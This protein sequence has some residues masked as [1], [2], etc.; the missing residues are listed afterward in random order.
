MG[1]VRNLVVVEEAGAVLP[2]GEERSEDGGS[3]V[4]YCTDR[5]VRGVRSYVVRG[6]EVWG[7]AVRTGEVVGRAQLRGEAQGEDADGQEEFWKGEQP[8]AVRCV[9]HLVGEEAVVVVLG[10]G[11][12]HLV[13]VDP[14]DEAREVTCDSASATTTESAAYWPSECVAVLP[15]GISAA[16][17]SPSGN[18]LAIVGRDPGRVMVLSVSDGWANVLDEELQVYET[19]RQ[20]CVE[21]AALAWSD[22]DK[23]LGVSFG[24]EAFE[25]EAVTR[26]D[27]DVILYD[28]QKST[29]ASRATADEDWTA[30]VPG[31]V[32]WFS[33]G[34][35]LTVPIRDTRDPSW[36]LKL[37]MVEKNGLEHGTAD[38][39]VPPLATST[40]A[41]P[42]NPHGAAAQVRSLSWNLDGTLLAMWVSLADGTGSVVQVYHRA[43][44]HWLVKHEVRA[45][46]IEGCLWDRDEA[47]VLHVWTA[48]EV[49]QR[50]F[51]W[52]V[53][54]GAR[55]PCVG[56][57]TDGAALALT[58]LARAPVP[59]PMSHVR[60]VLPAVPNAV[61][62][63]HPL[64]VAELPDWRPGF[65][66][67]ADGGSSMLMPEDV[68]A[69]AL[70]AAVSADGSLLVRDGRAG[71]EASWSPLGHADPHCGPLLSPH[72]AVALSP[73]GLAGVRQLAWVGARTLVLL[74]SSHGFGGGAA[75][76]GTLRG[77]DFLVAVRL[78]GDQA[79]GPGDLDVGMRM[80]L[81][82]DEE[83]RRLEPS[84]LAVVS[85]E[86]V[87]KRSPWLR[88][89]AACADGSV[90]SV[91]VDP[92]TLD[93]RARC[94]PNPADPVAFGRGEDAKVN[95]YFTEA[96]DHFGIALLPPAEAVGKGGHGPS[97]G[98]ASDADAVGRQ[99][100]D[101]DMM[102]NM[103]SD[104][105][106]D[107]YND[108]F[109]RGDDAAGGS[110][111]GPD[112]DDPRMHRLVPV[113]LTSTLHLH[114][115][116]VK[117]ATE[118]TS[119]AAHDT[120]LLV[121]TSNR[122]LR[123]LALLPASGLDSNTP[124]GPQDGAQ[125]L[126]AGEGF[127]IARPKATSAGTATLGALGSHAA[128]AEGVKKGFLEFGGP[129]L[130]PAMAEKNPTATLLPPAS[131]NPW[132]NPRVKG[133]FANA[134]R[135]LEFGAILVCAVRGGAGV[136]LQ[137]PRG[138]LE[139]LYPRALTLGLS[140]RALQRGDFGRAFALCKRHRLDLNLLCD[141]DP[142]AFLQA[143]R[144]GRVV[145]S[146]FA[147]EEAHHGIPPPEQEEA[148]RT[149]GSV[150][151]LGVNLFLSHLKQDNVTESVHDVEYWRR[152]SG[153]KESEEMHWGGERKVQA[154]MGALRESLLVAQE[155]SI[156]NGGDARPYTLCVLTSYVR[157]LPSRIEDAL[158]VLQPHF[159]PK[160]LAEGLPPTFLRHDTNKKTDGDTFLQHLIWVT[161]GK[162]ETLWRSALGMY[163]FYLTLAVL[164]AMEDKDPKEYMPW[165]GKLHSIED[166]DVQKF[167]INEHLGRHPE[168]LVHL[169]AHARKE[170]DNEVFAKCLMFAKKHVLFRDLLGHFPAGE[171]S[172]KCAGW[173]A[174][175]CV[176]YAQ[177]LSLKGLYEDSA[178]M[179]LRGG[180]F[181][182]AFQQYLHVG[183][184]AQA[185]AVA[186][187]HLV[188]GD[189]QER[190]A[191]L[192]GFARKVAGPLE[193][194]SR[195]LDAGR[196]LL[197]YGGEEDVVEGLGHL[198]ASGAWAEVARQC[199][200]RAVATEV[201][202]KHVWMP[203][204]ERAMAAAGELKEQAERFTKYLTRL[205]VVR[206]GL[207]KELEERR[208]LIEEEAERMR[209]NEG[210]GSDVELDPFFLTDTFGENPDR[211]WDVESI[212]SSL[213]QYT[214]KTHA[215]RA[216]TI[217]RGSSVGGS[218]V[219][220]GRQ[221]GVK[222]KQK[223]GKKIRAGHPKEEGHLV[224]LLENMMLG[225]DVVQGYGELLEMICAPTI[226]LPG[227]EGETLEAMERGLRAAAQLQVTLDALLKLQDASAAEIRK[228]PMVSLQLSQL[229]DDAME[230]SGPSDKAK[231]KDKTAPHPPAVPR[232]GS[233]KWAFLRPPE[234]IKLQ[235][236]AERQQVP[237]PPS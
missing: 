218:T 74:C 97:N 125:I 69:R 146:F 185:M 52:D 25:G 145:K 193:T 94:V 205:R 118:V 112:S 45:E 217:A 59:P 216:T 202:Q 151:Q 169:A 197:E 194:V 55:P 48:S 67:E 83:V 3:N 234:S 232:G 209:K 65:F 189:A 201:V 206:K 28:V 161:P 95:P 237:A 114:M 56:C 85:G 49:R 110:A 8:L 93:L 192:A 11:E 100:Q 224:G 152:G 175:C 123:P 119:F 137:Q 2:C 207:E 88:C 75:S 182:P 42:P 156:A 102:T 126:Y 230:A 187:R 34:S 179:Y 64:D 90:W 35:L 29:V 122:V 38:L 17:V 129:Q 231:D 116:G 109:V 18:Y 43:N 86:E 50:R 198:V 91:E 233:W 227:T 54:V 7:V 124:Q 80:E 133:Q 106:G 173:H 71:A 180:S 24:T 228:Q 89:F 77:H 62:V 138:N 58:A 140:C 13:S 127:P 115:G 158:R 171:S 204:V 200:R 111:L 176:A 236:S 235:Q 149:Y 164:R 163:D 219:R 208:K 39:V 23:F 121:T 229:M 113:G 184:W 203:G 31:A 70:V 103:S 199:A 36:T 214:E 167:E 155:A 92:A 51:V 14:L 165:L 160:P 210:E 16:Q 53:A 178:L 213:S 76:H 191:L 44:Y 131:S 190:T 66:G 196:V 174:Q 60:L 33:N 57:V 6:R 9:E 132:G 19:S 32:A 148:K 101:M 46:G 81:G 142:E 181:M 68:C 128:A 147:V 47:L 135:M 20:G 222:R 27:G 226:L 223:S 12:V 183:R 141:F 87:P 188:T 221:Q 37:M 96:C 72:V 104:D 220:S 215:S 195:T 139:I 166:P 79:E 177:A 84:P 4:G 1:A 82:P 136:I 73:L 212:S 162:G 22:D 61:A 168:A 21:R 26:T 154:V 30:I 211:N 170:G 130:R 186:E 144:D 63:F 120:H 172:E 78:K 107:V 98:S 143:C 5:C 117:V 134:A 153:A 40:D 10:A 159:V 105:D 41:R 99:L 225:K 150:D 108:G 157:D 15:G